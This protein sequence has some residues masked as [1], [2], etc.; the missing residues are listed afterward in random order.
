MIV[1]NNC[2]IVQSVLGAK[3]KIQTNDIGGQDQVTHHG[4]SSIHWSMTR[5]HQVATWCFAADLELIDLEWEE[6]VIFT[7]LLQCKKV[8]GCPF[9]LSPSYILIDPK[10]MI[11]VWLSS[12]N[13]AYVD[14][15]TNVVTLLSSL[16]Y[17]PTI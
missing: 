17:I 12:T 9:G 13:V 2:I 15:G 5:A 6:V 8:V 1:K 4:G 16:T 3:T 7:Q 11:L 14:S 10:V